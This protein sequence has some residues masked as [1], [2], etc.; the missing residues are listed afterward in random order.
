MTKLW[1]E[2]KESLLCYEIARLCIAQNLKPHTIGGYI[3]ANLEKQLLIIYHKREHYIRKA[4]KALE[5]S[6]EDNWISCA[7][8]CGIDGELYARL[9]AEF[10]ALPETNTAIIL[11][12]MSGTLTISKEN[13]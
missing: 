9:I 4:Q 11:P 3:V 13:A 10:A 6:Q 2:T 8:T 5:L 7:E 12:Y 1:P